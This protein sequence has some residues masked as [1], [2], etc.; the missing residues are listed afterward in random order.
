MFDH[1]TI[2]VSD[3]DA[4]EKFFDTVLIQLGIETQLPDQQL[5][6]VGRLLPDHPRRRRSTRHDRPARRVRRALARA[7]RR[8]LAGG[9]RRRLRGR[10]PARAAD[11]VPA[12]T[13]TARSCAAP[14]ATA[15]RRSTTATVRR[16]GPASSTT[17]GSASRDLAASTAFYRVVAEC[18]R[19]RGAPRG[20]RPHDDRRRRGGR[21]RSSPASHP[22][23]STW[24]SA[25]TTPAVDR[26]H[27][28]LTAAGYEDHGAARRAPPLPPR[29]LRRLRARS[30]RQ[31]HRGRQP[32]PDLG[33][34]GA[35]AR[36]DGA[37]HRDEDSR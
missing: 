29:L 22:S 1:V 10:R 34:L 6:G 24:P 32:Q 27:A 17:S 20:R 28:S 30:R 21:S 36:C 18:A 8:V 25:A 23:T 4:S 12:P 37:Y 14:M 35:F 2:H 31:Q 15:S 7:G 33:P 11:G 26:F 19:A 3:R 9:R 13:T 5:L 16:S